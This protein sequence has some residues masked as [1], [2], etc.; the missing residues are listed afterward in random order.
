MI[1]DR[2]EKHKSF[3]R[4]EKLEYPLLSFTIGSELPTCR[5]EEGR[6]LAAQLEQEN[7]S[8]EPRDL[9]VKKFGEELQRQY[10]QL[11]SI[12][13]DG[14]FT[15]EPFAGIPW[16]EAI[17]GCDI[18]ATKDSFWAYPRKKE[19][20]DIVIDQ[21]WVD[22]YL[23]FCRILDEVGKGK[24]PVG[25]PILRGPCDV[26]GTLMGQSQFVLALA[27]G[28]LS[29]R[30][31]IESISKIFLYL[32]SKQLEIISPFAGG[33]SMG[34][35][36]IWCPDKCLWFQDDL[37]SLLNPRLC[38]NHLLDIY[39]NIASAVPITMFHLHPTS[40]FILDSLLE[41]EPLTA[42]EV[43]KDDGG[44]SIAEM[45]PIFKRILKKKCLVI[46]G[47]L[48]VKDI[49]VIRQG[50]MPNPVFLHIVA[51]NVENAKSLIIAAK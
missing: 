9:N 3:W 22:L 25:Q 10:E 39:F 51:E 31:T 17:C 42:I 35:Y 1:D 46:W 45:V 27:D 41:I 43:N 8:L 2:L 29:I 16:M 28:D 18:Y 13:Q 5:F 24:F 38:R 34:F 19:L 26:A 30:K 36:H 12:D 15:A 44:P 37:T 14:F 7:I 23:D 47:K 50:L 6:R 33:Y 4:R 48:D 20:D 11:F 49:S 21:K 40:F 32:V